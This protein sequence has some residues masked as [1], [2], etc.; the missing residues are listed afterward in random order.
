MDAL[1]AQLLEDNTASL[2]DDLRIIQEADPLEYRFVL[3]R[4][5]TNSDSSALR[6]IGASPGWLGKSDRT[7]RLVPLANRLAASRLIQADHHIREEIPKMLEVVAYLAYNST[8]DR[9]RLQAARDWLDR[10]GVKSVDKVQLDVTGAVSVR[11]IQDVLVQV[12]GR[13]P[14]DPGQVI[15]GAWGDGA[16][17]LDDEGTGERG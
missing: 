5:M 11:S 13:R 2:Q 14:E 10:A 12:Y 9:V 1:Q 16:T 7:S 15:D 8:D 3:A 17:G 6:T 4:S